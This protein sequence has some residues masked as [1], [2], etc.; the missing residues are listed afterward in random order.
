MKKINLPEMNVVFPGLLKM[1]WN[2]IP[3]DFPP[4]I[5]CLSHFN[6]AFFKHAIEEHKSGDYDKAI[7]LYRKAADEGSQLACYNLGNYYLF[8]VGVEK[9]T[10]K[11][12]EWWE[13]GGQIHPNQVK[14]FQ[15]LS[16][17]SFFTDSSHEP[18][19]LF[20][21]NHFI[22]FINECFSYQVFILTLRRILLMKGLMFF[23]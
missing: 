15:L 21:F 17:I 16:N 5:K 12:V 13:R 9:N 23:H 14:L 8:G 20:I 3:C 6:Q 22:I 11:F 1:K 18:T 19:C 10:D 2:L 4:D 7:E